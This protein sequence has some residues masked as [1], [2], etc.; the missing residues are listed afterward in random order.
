M[1]ICFSWA[2]QTLIWRAARVPRVASCA[3]SV[4]LICISDYM[5]HREKQL[6]LLTICSLHVRI[7][8]LSNVPE[9]NVEIWHDME[10]KYAMKIRYC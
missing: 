2:I 5:C 1:K 8:K 4:Y 6:D 3:S 10:L 9:L 7:L